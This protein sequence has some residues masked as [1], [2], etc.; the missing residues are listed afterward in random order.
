MLRSVVRSLPEEFEQII[1]DETDFLE[2]TSTG[3]RE[4]QRERLKAA[5]VQVEKHE[6][7]LNKRL[8][9]AN[10]E[11]IKLGRENLLIQKRQDQL[12]LTKRAL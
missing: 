3:Q 10:E 1:E 4:R 2:N 6:E 5:L 9:K 11:A 8:G 12:S 7:L